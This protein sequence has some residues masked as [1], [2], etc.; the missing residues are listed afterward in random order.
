MSSAIL[1]FLADMASEI[2]TI[3]G[4]AYIPLV[5]LI[6]FRAGRLRGLNEDNMAERLGDLCF[7]TLREEIEKLIN[8]C[9]RLY[10]GNNFIL[11]PGKN[12]RDIALY[13][14]GDSED[15]EQL[16]TIIKNLNEL[17]IQSNEFTQILHFFFGG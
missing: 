6:V 2:L 8:E 9:L 3:I 11:P 4:L 17:G 16:L 1:E 10:F 13:L 5:T 15:L 12:L 7:D 14:H